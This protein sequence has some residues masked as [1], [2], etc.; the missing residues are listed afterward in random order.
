MMQRYDPKRIP[1]LMVHGLMSTP[2]SFANLTN[3]LFADPVIH[4]RYQIWHYH[5][6]TGT[7]LLQNAA[8]LRRILKQTLS[9]IDPPGGDFAT[10]HLVVLGHSMGGLM[11]H[12]LISDSGYKLWDSVITARPEAFR[13]DVKTGNALNAVFLFERENRIRRA[14][15]ISVPHRGSPIAGNWIGSLGQTLYRADRELQE[16]FW[17]LVENHLD[18]I[19]PFFSRSLKEGKLSAI[20]TLSV[21]SPVLMALAEIPPAIPFHSIIGQ[22]NAGPRQTGTDGVVAY[23]SSHLDGAESE[24]IIPFGHEAFL[25][26]DAVTEIKRI[27]HL[28]LESL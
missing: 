21:N 17:T 28:H 3:D 13:C 4:A 23:A 7:P 25:H 27:L 22:I 19:N 9:E 14:I 24:A 15:L 5:Y 2:I 10:N 20:H 26:P 8:L 6:P 18:Q 12:T 1:L 11:A 16:A